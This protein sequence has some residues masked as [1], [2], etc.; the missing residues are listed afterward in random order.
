[1]K[2]K[3]SLIKIFVVAVMFSAA[4]ILSGCATTPGAGNMTGKDF[5][6]EAK[7]Q[8]A[9]INIDEAKNMLGKE[10]VVFLD[11]R[12]PKEYKAGHVPGAV[13]LARG[14]LEFKILKAVPDKNATVVLYCKTGG[15]SALATYS[16]VRMGYKGVISMDG[17]WVAWSKKGYPV[18]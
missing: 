3:S 16:L 4:F 13:N 18:E 2:R 11:V 6:A 17:G 15:R 7:T 12:E 1:M 8:I 9:A 10:G 5:V 14:L